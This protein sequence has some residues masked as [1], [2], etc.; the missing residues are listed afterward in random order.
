[1]LV[2]QVSSHK[3]KLAMAVRGKNKQYRLRGIHAQLGAAWAARSG[4]PALWMQ[5]IEY[6]GI[7]RNPLE[8]IA[9]PIEPAPAADL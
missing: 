7:V 9:R 4:S 3:A 6:A 1:L 2:H 8:G 5:L